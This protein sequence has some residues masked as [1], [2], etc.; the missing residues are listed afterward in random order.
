MPWLTA[1]VVVF[2][3]LVIGGGIHGYM[4][5]SGLKSLVPA[6]ISG[7]LLLASAALSKSHP[8]LGYG[9]AAVLCVALMGFFLPRYFTGKAGVWPALIVG[10]AAGLTFL[11][12]V[13]GHFMGSR[14]TP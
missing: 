13:V 5:P 12:L 14:Q 10:I 6:L 1:V 9:F 8:K 4:G 11:A 2:A 7:M 3:L